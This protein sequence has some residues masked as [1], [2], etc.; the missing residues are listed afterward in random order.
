MKIWMQVV[1]STMK[2][3]KHVSQIQSFIAVPRD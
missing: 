3:R 1:L 2:I